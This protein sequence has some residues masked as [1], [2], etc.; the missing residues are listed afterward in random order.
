[1]SWKINYTE[2]ARQDLR[3]IFEY[4]SNELCAYDT[5][6]NQTRRIMKCISELENMPK[7]YQVF[8]DEPW[9]S[10]GVRI[11][12][13]DNYLVFYLP[14]DKEKVVN[15]VRIMYGGRDIKKQLDE[16]KEF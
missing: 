14:K 15:I 2:Q 16:T 11:L 1:M 7:R 10:M 12:P 6:K 3:N 5:A 9:S 8:E 4:I 13:I